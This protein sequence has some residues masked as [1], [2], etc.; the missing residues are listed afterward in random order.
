VLTSIM[1]SDGNSIMDK[2][3]AA[4]LVSGLVAGQREAITL[5]MELYADSEGVV[6]EEAGT[7]LLKLGDVINLMV[8]L[9]PGRARSAQM[10]LRRNKG[11]E[12]TGAAVTASRLGHYLKAQHEKGTSP[13]PGDEMDPAYLRKALKAL[14]RTF[15]AQLEKLKRCVGFY[16]FADYMPSA[17]GVC[18]LGENIFFFIEEKTKSYLDSLPEGYEDAIEAFLY[19]LT[20]HEATELIMRGESDTIT[21]EID[22]EIVAF[23]FKACA[24]FNITAEGPMRDKLLEFARL[25][26]AMEPEIDNRFAPVLMMLETLRGKIPEDLKT[27]DESVLKEVETFITKYEEYTGMTMNVDTIRIHVDRIHEENR[28]IIAIRSIGSGEE[29]IKAADLPKTLTGIVTLFISIIS[30]TDKPAKTRMDALIAVG[31]SGIIGN[32]NLNNA[33]IEVLSDDETPV[34]VA[35]EAATALS[36]I[37]YDDN[38]AKEALEKLLE[39]KGLKVELRVRIAEA[40][41]NL[42]LDNKKAF[43]KLTE[44]IGKVGILKRARMRALSALS[45]MREKLISLKAAGKLNNLADRKD[46]MLFSQNLIRIELTW[47]EDIDLAMEAVDLLAIFGAENSQVPPS[48][49]KVIGHTDAPIA[50]RVKAL[51][52]LHHLGK[53]HRGKA[54]QVILQDMLKTGGLNSGEAVKTAH[55]LCEINK[56][57]AD[58]I[59]ELL[60]HVGNKVVFEDLRIE[61]LEVLRENA[62][63]DVRVKTALQDIIDDKDNNV[64]FRIRAA[65]TLHIIDNGNSKA[66]RELNTIAE[67]TMV[68]KAD[69]IDAMAALAGLGI[70]SQELLAQLKRM[71]HFDPDKRIRIKAAGLMA[72]IEPGNPD[73]VESLLEIYGEISETDTEVRALVLKELAKASKEIIA[74]ST[75]EGAEASTPNFK[76]ASGTEA[77]LGMKI[78]PV[79]GPQFFA[80]RVDGEAVNADVAE[81]VD[82]FLKTILDLMDAADHDKPTILALE[83]DWIPAEQRAIIQPLLSMIY[84]IAGKNGFGNLIIMHGKAEGFAGK[85]TAKCDETGT[86]LHQVIVLA[87][88]GSILAGLFNEL[89]STEEKKGALLAGINPANLY[90]AKAG[91]VNNIR[92][93][94]MFSIAMRLAMDESAAVANE[95]I[96]V[97]PGEIG[98]KQLKRFFILIPKEEPIDFEIL[99]KR[100]ELQHKAIKQYV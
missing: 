79:D 12:E 70:L 51:M 99:K 46:M 45:N 10:P 69:K 6:N 43:D 66:K 49:T 4:S 17:A 37:G 54:P 2:R 72:T 55:A 60:G 67:S 18:T 25:I 73:V 56:G 7:I 36:N 87:S 19:L 77:S 65:E 53:R 5:L 82:V 15:P 9:D 23:L 81:I 22:S 20:V 50:L 100:Y 64:S 44:I 78:R 75:A 32:E 34:E 21:P 91:T 71:S 16:F 80:Q 13:I 47:A 29:K 33:V 30:D 11:A 1:N 24:Y 59:N 89:M 58:A 93:L 94:E 57:H 38:D 86:P 63:G 61:A 98:G 92:L 62:V 40:L 95:F 27:I 31:D 90:S 96:D 88:Q 97:T 41:L 42:D 84:R 26:D 85:I 8:K 35:I 48:L 28:R 52:A 39:K 68:S 76:E 74:V 83:T 3:D 14:G